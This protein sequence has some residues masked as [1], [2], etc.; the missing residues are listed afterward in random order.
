LACGAETPSPPSPTATQPPIAAA[1][2]APPTATATAVPTA[3]ATPVPSP[4]PFPDGW[5]LPDLYTMPPEDFRIERNVVTGQPELRFTSSVANLG[6]G[7]LVLIGAYDAAEDKTRA[8]QRI[9]VAGG[10]VVEHYVG[11]FVFHPT[12]DHWHFENFNLFELWSFGAAGELEELL[13]SSGKH[14]WCITETAI[15]QPL[16]EIYDPY[17]LLGGCDPE[18]Q[19]IATGWVD[20]YEWNLP[21]QELSLA[22]IAD[23]QYAFVSTV[24]PDALVIELDYENNARTTYI[25]IREGTV[26]VLELELELELDEASREPRGNP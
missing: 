5:R 18:M 15:Y 12:H 9:F 19:A 8:I 10:E 21:G 13:S 20:T 23:G 2:M 7:P 14:S 17:S 22:G 16:P 1:T 24:N 4:T 11:H 26:T 6:T 25:E 3:T